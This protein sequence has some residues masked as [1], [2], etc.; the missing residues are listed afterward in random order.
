MQLKW[1]RY[2]LENRARLDATNNDNELPIDLADGK[3]TESFL[4]KYID[5]L[6]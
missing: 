4:T 2:L 3:E 1:R 5:K 6:G